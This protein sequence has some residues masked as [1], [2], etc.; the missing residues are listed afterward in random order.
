MNFVKIPHK[1]RKQEMEMLQIYI[2]TSNQ[3]VQNQRKCN[4]INIYYGRAQILHF[5]NTHM[6]QR[7]VSFKY[8]HASHNWNFMVTAS[9]EAC[10]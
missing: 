9:S 1:T 4:E 8:E 7:G 6:G 10:E 3:T 2:L 5:T